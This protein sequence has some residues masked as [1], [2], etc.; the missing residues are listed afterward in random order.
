MM[1][2]ISS[3]FYAMAHSWQCFWEPDGMPGYRTLVGCSHTNFLPSVLSLLSQ[4]LRFVR[5]TRI[6]DAGLSGYWQTFLRGLPIP[7]SFLN[8]FSDIIERPTNNW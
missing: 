8:K 4:S 1:L 6:N 7:E 3:W 2:R 5:L